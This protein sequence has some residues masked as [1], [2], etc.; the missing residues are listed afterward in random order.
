MAESR[1][2]ETWAL[3]LRVVTDV[4]MERLRRRV[5]GTITEV[6]A[7]P[8]A[9]VEEVVDYQQNAAAGFVIACARAAALTS[10]IVS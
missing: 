4:D 3:E 8:Q 6:V 7:C 2:R 1:S 9:Q 10:T 5:S